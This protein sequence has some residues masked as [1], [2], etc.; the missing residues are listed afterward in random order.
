MSL[1]L[2]WHLNTFYI[3]LSVV[4]C[5]GDLS[6]VLFVLQL[7]SIEVGG[8]TLGPQFVVEALA[9]DNPPS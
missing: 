8:L 7:Y 2:G 5:F 1:S 4:V 3:M 9:P 6:D